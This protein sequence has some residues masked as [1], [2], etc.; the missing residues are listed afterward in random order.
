[1]QNF[2]NTA[3]QPTPGKCKPILF[4]TPM[5][6][7]ILRGEKTQTRVIIKHKNPIESIRPIMRCIENEKDWDKY[8]LTDELGEVFLIKPKYSVGDILWVQETWHPKRHNMPTGYKYE[9]KAT[10]Q[11]DGNP[12]DEPWRPAMHMPIEACRIFLKVTKIRVERLED[13]TKEDAIAEGI[14][15]WQ[16]AG[17]TRYKSYFKPVVGF[18]DTHDHPLGVHAAVASFRSLWADIHGFKSLND[19]PW[20]FVY[21]FKHTDH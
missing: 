18:W 7:A 3:T 6:Q 21:E 2:E 19:N 9:Y 14:E 8:I 13:I 5:I 15:K 20:V 4:A 11:E 10:A 16:Q 17:Y 12:T 1:M